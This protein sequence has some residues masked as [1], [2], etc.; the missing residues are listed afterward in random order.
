LLWAIKG[1]T[2]IESTFN[3]A[4]T[5]RI[6][7]AIRKLTFGNADDGKTA[8]VRTCQGAIMSTLVPGLA[9]RGAADAPSS[10]KKTNNGC[11]FAV[12]G[13]RLAV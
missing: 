5:R 3:A 11:R 10:P 6:E 4:V 13:E 7:S 8:Q 1:I 12:L 2:L 9:R